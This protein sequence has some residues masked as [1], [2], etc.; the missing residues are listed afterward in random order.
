[1]SVTSSYRSD[2]GLKRPNNE[3]AVGALEPKDPRLL[4]QSGVL[5]VVADG[6]GGHEKGEWAS[7]HVV[8]TLLNGYYSLSHPPDQR[9]R[10]LIERANTEIY[11]E[12]K[13]TLAEGERMATTVLAAA[14]HRGKLYLAHVGDSRAY[15]IRGERIYR[16]T[17]DHSVVAEMVR[18]GALTEDE[19]RTSKLRNRLTR[20]V[21]SRPNV[22]VEVSQPI[23]LQPG[24][25]LLLCTDGLTQYATDLDLL[26]AA[27]GEPKEIVERLIKF[28]N[29]RGGSDNITVAAIRYGQPSELPVS[30][31]R[32]AYVAVLILLLILGF[33]PAMMLGQS[34][35][36]SLPA[37][38]TSTST[39]TSVVTVLP[40]PTLT[41]TPTE[42]P[43]A[44]LSPTSTPTEIPTPSSTPALVTCEYIVQRGD[45]AVSIAKRFGIDLNAISFANERANRSLDRIFPGD[46]LLLQNVLAEVCQAQGGQIFSVPT[47]FL[48]PS[49]V[50]SSTPVFSPSPY[51]ATP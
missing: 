19:A 47:A 23:P 16:L 1:M 8:Q 32:W 29:D 9:L 28:A 3:D 48:V 43:T 7:Q 15:L 21:G 10:M 4:R 5:Y 11:Q 12:A 36:F 27:Y 44:T 2:R 49:P 45:I 42:S 14:I 26:T 6:L 37:T 24:D 40:S 17:Q 22:E 13:R 34:G 39:S 38:G 33:F 51:P 41:E 30:L 35:L 20:S 31:P 50:P 18:S 25:L 46:R